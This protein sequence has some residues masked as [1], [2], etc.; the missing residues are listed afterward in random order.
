MINWSAEGLVR[1][2]ATAAAD[3]PAI[4][5]EAGITT[6]ANLDDRTEAL[7]AAIRAAGVE[8]GEIVA[9]VAE[10]TADAIGAI[11]GV[12]RAGAV[13]AP[14]PTGLA[15]PE[16]AA[17]FE[18]LSPVLVVHDPEHA[19]AVTGAGQRGL[20]IPSAPGDRRSVPGDRRPPEPAARSDGSG[21]RGSSDLDPGSPDVDPEV[22]AV[23]VLTSGTTGRPKG[24][25]L[26]RRAMAASADSWLAA[27][28]PASGWLL[29]LGLGHVAGLGVV[30][31]AI[32]G[33]VPIW[34]GSRR[35]SA[36]L[37]SALAADPGPSHVSLVPTQLVRLLDANTDPPPSGLR[38]VLLGGGPILP[39]LVTRAARAGWPIV[40]TYG[41]S[42]AGSG[43]TALPTD[44][45][46]G[47]PESAGR[48]LPGVEVTI[49]QPDPDGV[50]EIVV[51][52]RARFSGYLGAAPEG[53]TDPVRTGDLGRLDRDG[54][55]IVVDRRLDRIVRGGANISPAEVEAVLM[56]H[57]AIVDAAV[58]GLPDPLWGQV[59]A[60]AVVLRVGSRDPG[61][62]GDPGHPSDA[63]LVAH[64]R[65]SLAPYKIPVAFRRLDALPRTTGGK[66]RRDAVR[67]LL[68]GEPSGQLARPDG[69][70]LGWRVTGAG[71]LAVLVL[72]GTL[73]NAQQLDRLAAVLAVPGD[74][75]VHA[76]DR[77]GSGTG[78]LAPGLP[79]AGLDLA[80]HLADIVAYLDA[81]GIERTAVLGI[82]FGGVLAIELA[83]RHPTRVSAVVA[84]EPPYGPVADQATREMFGTLAA[85]TVKAHRTA[86]PAAA[87]ETFLRAVAG[88]DAWDRLPPRTRAAVAREGDGAAADAALV[89]ARP[90]E[91][92]RITAPVT[93]LTGSASDPF[94]AQIAD[95]VVARIPGARRAILDGLSHVSPI[96]QPAI[97]GGAVRSALAAAGIVIDP[98][99]VP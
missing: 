98:E 73:S 28:P 19:T 50:G 52:T 47:H 29:A 90:D 63:D 24:V 96:T 95:A 40:P 45:A 97:V 71:P 64:A 74:V 4:L 94:Y 92:D 57:P 8:P 78:R 11:L 14:V 99:P 2:H 56:T 46:L 89:G 43:A 32:A 79:V 69:A 6:W 27:L 61:D 59:P 65:A 91:L 37:L 86:G 85:A 26:S 10:P 25:L 60:A 80:I 54:R 51:T 5:D 33:R 83:A 20:A 70:A 93:I 30:W 49:D 48:A 23:I 42:E 15:M 87:A 68:A 35:D 17:S 58:V 53:A 3:A 1:S 62:P 75:T 81:R 34:I 76:L 84:Y 67:A 16:L 72:P 77:R 66:L 21:Q 18:V 39:D 13:A 38:A 9:V 88:P 41:L 82:S 31:R 12:L 55:L 7:A 44:E 36:G 22:P